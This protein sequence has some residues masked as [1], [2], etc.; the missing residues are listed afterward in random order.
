MNFQPHC[1]I[2]ANLTKD[3]KEK[4]K[5]LFGLEEALKDEVKTLDTMMGLVEESKDEEEK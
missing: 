1:E 4:R 5:E 3:I 2:I